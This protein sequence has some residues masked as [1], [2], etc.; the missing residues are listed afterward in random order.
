[1][2]R[3]AK[4]C[5]R[6]IGVMPLESPAT[7]QV[8]EVFS[9]VTARAKATMEKSA[10]IVEELAELTRGNVDAVVAYSAPSEGMELLSKDR[11]AFIEKT[12][13]RFESFADVKSATDF[14]KL[15][16]EYARAALDSA[17]SENARLSETLLELSGESADAESARLKIALKELRVAANEV[18]LGSSAGAEKRHQRDHGLGSAPRD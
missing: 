5:E 8:R 2:E 18:G 14:F 17:V 10:K 7:E 13:R 4:A 3:I 1:M 16:G 11:V 15:Q 6:D 9:D 12:R